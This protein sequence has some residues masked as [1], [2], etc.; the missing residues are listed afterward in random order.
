MLGDAFFHHFF[1]ADESADSQERFGLGRRSRS[2]RLREIR[3][4][5]R[6]YHVMRGVRPADFRALLEELG[7]SFVKIGQTLS[8]RSEI[9]PKVYC[10]ELT[11]LQANVT[12]LPFDQ[13]ETQ[14]RSIYGDKFDS[15]FQSI[16]PHPL[17]SASL[18]QVHKAML[19]SGEVV[20]VKVQR[21]GVKE[22]MAQDID[23]MRTVAQ[24]MTM[25]MPD[26]QILDLRSVIEEMWKTFLEETDFAREAKNLQRFAQLNKDVAFVA[27]P[28][29]YSDLCSE[30]VVVME[31]IDGIPI[32]NSKALLEQEYDLKEIG[33]KMLDNYTSQILDHGF[34]H[35]DPHP[36]NIMIRGGQIVYI[37]L[38]NMGKLTPSERSGF[39]RII[40]AVG[41][42]DSAALKDALISFAIVRDNSTIDHTSFLADL[43]LLLEDYGTGDLGDIDI[44]QFLS[45]ILALTRASKVTLPSSITNVSRGIVT[46]EGT[47]SPYIPN[48]NIIAIINNHIQNSTD[49]L[50]EMRE[51]LEETAK[52]TEKAAK[53]TLQT[54]QYAGEALKMLTRGQ[55]RVNTEMLGSEKPLLGLSKIMNRLTIAIITAG[56]FIGSSL[57][58]PYSTGPL[59]I[60]LPTL[61]FFGYSGALVL[62][63]WVVVDIW[64]RH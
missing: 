9:L 35:A 8:T 51:L 19:Q 32:S 53:G 25:V 45:D 20:A 2:K 17:G 6:K 29:V 7:P 52:A 57:I 47:I 36:G 54:A 18:A 63:I 5:M 12:P 22:T 38:G 48:E 24:R 3:S 34:F 31:Y 39:G 21:P 62:S 46:I 55:L 16:D 61:S 15:I 26:E 1:N 4:L 44:G 11:K 42:G 43:D 23:I 28:K 56:L 40:K 30:Q 33:E 14:L 50:Q 58:A 59:I 37:D 10:D 13:V 64:R 60:G 27:C 41:E 49:R